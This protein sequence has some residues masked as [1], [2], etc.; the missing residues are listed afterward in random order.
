[1]NRI[2]GSDLLFARKQGD[3]FVFDESEARRVC[4]RINTQ[5]LEYAA[6][7]SADG[8]ELFFT[9]LSETAITSGNVR[10][11]IMRATRTSE[12]AA[13]GEP[14]VIGAIGT[15]D[16]VEG[17]AITSEGRTLYY[18]KREGDKFRLCKVTRWRASP[19]KIHRSH[20]LTA[21]TSAWVTPS[22]EPA[23]S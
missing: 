8:L 22:T 19:F 13:F 6:S 15:S 3:A 14:G 2:V 23:G 11:F 9:R 21:T 18:H 20:A 5:D 10:S 17:P 7:I 4:A 1:V 16:F 12:T